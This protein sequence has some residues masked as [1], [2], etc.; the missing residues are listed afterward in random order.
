VSE[1]TCAKVPEMATR[2]VAAAQR[3]APTATT[4][5]R[6]RVSVPSPT[7]EACSA[8]PTSRYTAGSRAS[9]ARSMMAARFTSASVRLPAAASAMSPLAGAAPPSVQL[10]LEL[11]MVSRARRPWTLRADQP[12]QTRSRLRVISLKFSPRWRRCE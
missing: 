10:V 5:E 8:A 4:W 11:G 7:G 2:N 1:R 12:K 9:S 6:Y 3:T